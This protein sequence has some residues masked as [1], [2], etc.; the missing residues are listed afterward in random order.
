MTRHLFLL[1]QLVL[2]MFS[3]PRKSLRDCYCYYCDYYHHHWLCCAAKQPP[4]T[5]ES[6]HHPATGTSDHLIWRRRQQLRHGAW[7]RSHVHV[8][9]AWNKAPAKKNMG[10]VATMGWRSCTE[11]SVTSSHAQ[12]LLL[13]ELGVP[14]LWW[15]LCQPPAAAVEVG[16]A[17]VRGMTSVVQRN[18]AW[19]CQ[20]VPFPSDAETA[21]GQCVF[22]RW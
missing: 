21:H 12:F 3:Q 15:S 18:I 19:C 7:S 5:P 20:I 9:A 1:P 11:I 4:E 14:R 16:G 13:P 10:L 2:K 8:D 22:N 17:C 6:P